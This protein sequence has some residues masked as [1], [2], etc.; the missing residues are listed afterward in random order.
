MKKQVLQIENVDAQELFGRLNYLKNEFYELKKLM[1]IKFH[2]S[3]IMTNAEVQDMLSISVS[4]V[5]NWTKKGIL[6]AYKIDGY[7]F[8]RRS[9]ILSQLKPIKK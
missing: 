1:T 5:R 2:E 9:Q 6:K 4:T 3:D 7:I 8:Y